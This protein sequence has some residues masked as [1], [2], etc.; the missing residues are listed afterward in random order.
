VDPAVNV[1]KSDLKAYQESN[2]DLK[3]LT[4]LPGET[5]TK[6]RIQP[7]MRKQKD[8][9]QGMQSRQMCAFDIRCAVVEHQ[10][11]VTMGD[12]G[13]TCEVPQPKRKPNGSLGVMAQESWVDKLDLPGEY[14]HALGF[15]IRH[16]SEAQLPLSKPSDKESGESNAS[17]TSSEASE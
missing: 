17:G 2:W 11:Y 13:E 9:T 7:L 8:A 4:I 10:N 6:F 3:H 15:M 12:D 1:D 5:P 16:I 14:L